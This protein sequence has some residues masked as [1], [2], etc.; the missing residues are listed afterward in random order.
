[1]NIQEIRQQFPQYDDLSDGDLLMGL[2][3][4]YY[5]DI[6]PRQFLNSIEG[7]G[8]AHVT[9]KN[10]E[11][12]TWWTENVSKPMGEETEAQMDERLARAGQ[13]P[14]DDGG[15]FG[16]AARSTLQG[17]TFGHGD[18]IVAAGAS[19]L[20]P[21]SYDY[22]LER[23]RQR[24]DQGREE[25][26]VLSTVSEI[27]GAVMLPIPAWAK[28]A[29][30]GT[31]IGQAAAQGG[32]LGGI[33]GFGAG[34]DGLTERLKDA[35]AAAAT[36]FGIGGALQGASEGIGAIVNSL[37]QR[38]AN[39][40][41]I[42]NAPTAEAI[43]QKA[44]D[45]YAAGRATGQQAAPGDTQALAAQV[46]QV[47]TDE[48]LI[49]PKGTVL[50]GESPLRDVLS[51]FDDYADEVMTPTQM[52]KVRGLINDAINSG[53]DAQ[54]RVG[55]QLKEMFDEWVDVRVPEFSKAYPYTQ[56]L[57]NNDMIDQAVELAGIR[58]GQFSGSG[59]ENALR[60][61][62]RALSRK[63]AKG[64]IKGLT[65]TQI[66]AINKIAEGGPIENIMR[67]IG[68]AAPR[69]VVS[70]GLAG[71][72][73]YM[74]GETIGG[75]A[76]GGAMAGASLAAGEVGRRV[77]TAMQGR[78]AEIAAALMRTGGI[79]PV[80]GDVAAPVVGAIGNAGSR[81]TPYLSEKISPAM[82]QAVQ[83]L[84]GR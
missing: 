62:F 16:T 48:G 49:T 21:N 4:K 1:M 25:R 29:N 56:R 63:I 2:H 76:L 22:E 72:V 17:L 27:G 33:Y 30:R 13:A 59:Y 80:V 15:A 31:R 50:R 71:G 45:L 32:V 5:P 69:G 19:M 40:E 58:A 60:T 23:E 82:R 20:G 24:L 12:K 70:T 28:S 38:K 36:G 67:D 43:G 66:D 64:Q 14:V 34:E 77:A 41:F 37:A 54:K 57:K 9:I 39:T 47:M 26:P 75:P 18:E 84:I 7:A 74:V 68:K 52:Q 65:Q 6:H 51:T 11:L 81:L 10:P 73:P 83:A 44:D 78:N 46:R 3:R 35:G 53:D 61:E 42:R 79:A 55:M 8:N